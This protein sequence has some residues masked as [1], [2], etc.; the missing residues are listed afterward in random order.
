MSHSKVFLVERDKLEVKKYKNGFLL[1]F[2]YASL[3][4][5]KAWP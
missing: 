5:Y 2:S 3:D 1:N 4:E